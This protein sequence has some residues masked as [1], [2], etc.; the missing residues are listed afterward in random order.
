MKSKARSKSSPAPAPQPPSRVGIQ[1]I[2]VPLDFSDAARKALVYAGWFAGKFGARL[3]LLHVIE[4]AGT[5]DFDKSSP[6]MPEREL[7]MERCRTELET[8]VQQEGLPVK[9]IERIDI[10][11]GRSY[12]EIADTARML[13]SDLIIISTHG[14]TGW[15]HTIFGSTTERVV[16]QA[17]CP[18][19]VVRE[20][21]KEFVP[22]LAKPKSGAK[23]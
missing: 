16:R 2:L 4:P 21:E 3:T 11:F 14:Y 15:K 23:A 18:V 5:P 6:P 7:I 12:N 19:L 1:S 8:I 10:R 22:A 20:H 13:N 9:L 17:P